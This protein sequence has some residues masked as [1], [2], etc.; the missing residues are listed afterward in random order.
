MKNHGLVSVLFILS[1][2]CLAGCESSSVGR[3][4]ELNSS[5]TQ[6][7]NSENDDKKDYPL[8]TDEIKA[9]AD[10]YQY[11]FDP[12]SILIK[13]R[14]QW[15]F[16][17]VELTSLSFVSARENRFLVYVFE[18]QFFIGHSGV[19]EEFISKIYLWD[20]GLYCGN[21]NNKEIKGYWY[22]SSLVAEK[23]QKDCLKM[24]SN[25]ANY[26]NINCEKTSGYYDYTAKIHISGLDNYPDKPIRG[27][28]Y[29]P[30][31][32][33]IIDTNG[34][35]TKRV[36]EKFIATNTSETIVETTWT[37]LR[38]TKKLEY[39]PVI[40]NSEINWIV[41]RG[42]VDNGY[43]L[44]APGDYQISAIYRGMSASKTLKV[45]G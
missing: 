43:K 31:V 38:V 45:T 26:E 18:D 16:T 19:Y 20:D 12:N 5:E 1:F 42:M 32:A 24:V 37:L 44:L 17:S 21:I 13:E 35:E 41:P 14:Q 23:D 29:Y 4:I 22:N 30:D 8:I 36:G 28:L 9:L 6:S 10:A 2:L 7:S 15:D 40:P 27:Y 11:N 3:S 39:T 25:I 34:Y 33:V